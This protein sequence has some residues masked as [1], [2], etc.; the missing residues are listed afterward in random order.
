MTATN[1]HVLTHFEQFAFSQ[2]L[3]C[4]SEIEGSLCPMQARG[5]G[6]QFYNTCQYQSELCFCFL[7][8]HFKVTIVKQR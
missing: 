4:F 3:V 5:G 8:A 2:G 7:G 6:V 1:Q